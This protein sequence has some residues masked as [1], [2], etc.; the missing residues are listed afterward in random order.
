M[1]ARGL[2]GGCAAQNLAE[3]CE[4]ISREQGAAYE[5][6]LKGQR[7]AYRRLARTSR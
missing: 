1:S 3:N 5:R 7:A 2:C 4:A 6:W